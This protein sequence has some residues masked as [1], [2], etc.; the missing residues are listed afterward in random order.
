MQQDTLWLGVTAIVLAVVTVFVSL[1][2][3]L[4]N[5]FVRKQRRGGTSSSSYRARSRAR[6]VGHIASERQ[7]HFSIDIVNRYRFVD[8]TAQK[9]RVCH[10]GS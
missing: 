9:L 7:G 2:A 8:Y 1:I 5:S 10:G 6:L 3:L 4:K